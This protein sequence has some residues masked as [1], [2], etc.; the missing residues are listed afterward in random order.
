MFLQLRRDLHHGRLLCGALDANV[1]ASYIIQGTI[2]LT[3][4]GWFT[5][6][7][8]CLVV[9]LRTPSDQR[10]EYSYF[11]FISCVFSRFLAEVGDYADVEKNE[12]YKYISE[13]KMLP[14]QTS[15]QEEKICEL[16]KTLTYVH[17][18]QG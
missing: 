15:K 11:N 7:F 16:H 5:F 4:G 18:H 9:F 2:F 8:K 6:F 14:K 17:E 13:F 1:L 12:D 10:R 3:R